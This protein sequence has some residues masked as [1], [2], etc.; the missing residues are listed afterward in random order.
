MSIDQ[1]DVATDPAL[2][3]KQRRERDIVGWL[4]TPIATFVLAPPLTM[5]LGF[6]LLTGDSSPAICR[7]VAT[8]NGCEE[9]TL[10]LIGEH[11]VIFAA[12]W[13]ILWALPWWRSLR[14]ARIVLAVIASVVL[15]AV[16][17]RMAAADT[18]SGADDQ[19]PGNTYQQN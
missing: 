11:V 4:L 10:G 9:L 17:I 7:G 16:P 19:Q 13:L 1:P 12:L 18:G 3:V 2:P 8:A 14:R 15:L 5:I 6:V